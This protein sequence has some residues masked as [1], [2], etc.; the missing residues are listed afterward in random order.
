MLY[1]GHTDV[2][3]IDAEATIDVVG[4]DALAE[5]RAVGVL[6][7]AQRYRRSQLVGARHTGPGGD[8]GAGGA[9]Q[10]QGQGDPD[11][12]QRDQQPVDPRVRDERRFGAATSQRRQRDPS[13]QLY[14]RH[15]ARWSSRTN[16]RIGD[17]RGNGQHNAGR[18]EQRLLPAGEGAEAV[19]FVL[20]RKPRGVLQS[21]REG[22]ARLHDG[23]GFVLHSLGG[24][25]RPR[26]RTA[27][28]REWAPT[29]RFTCTRSIR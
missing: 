23:R 27:C 11:R 17:R 2:L 12:D 26:S 20:S 5:R 28:W 10:A 7:D 8:A 19:R 3:N 22:A 24:A 4:A 25:G 29:A 6:G 15:D 1:L 16:R 18:V 21:R 13:R 14:G 9:A